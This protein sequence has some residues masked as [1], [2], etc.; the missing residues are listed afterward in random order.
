MNI[1]KISSA[2]L[3]VAVWTFL[4][5]AF[6]NASGAEFKVKE[7]SYNI[8]AYWAMGPVRSNPYWETWA[9]RIVRSLYDDLTISRTV[10]I[11]H[12]LLPEYII[13]KAGKLD[14]NQ[15]WMVFRITKKPGGPQ[16][17]MSQTR[18]SGKSSDAGNSLK[19]SVDWGDGDYVYSPQVIGV[20][21]DKAG[22][23]VNDKLIKSGSGKVLVDEIVGVGLQTPYYTYSNDVEQLRALDY[24]ERL[25]L[26]VV[27]SMEVLSADRTTMVASATRTIGYGISSP[28]KPVIGWEILNGDMVV[29]YQVVGGLTGVIQS[30]DQIGLQADWITEASVNGLG[31][32][33]RPSKIGNKFFRI[34]LI[35]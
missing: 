3:L 34:T 1:K 11:G 6:W 8:Q 35:P 20:V 33:K 28:P 31:N 15:L 17:S 14:Q 12:S 18:F 10:D 30:S 25:K 9:N 13:Q 32:I 22:E 7:E 2:V 21:W 19:S 29:T 24:V 23:R 4:L 27:Q 26:S 5:G 16:I